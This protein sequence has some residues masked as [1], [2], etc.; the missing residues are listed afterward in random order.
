MKEIPRAIEKNLSWLATMK[1]PRG[2][3]GPVVHYWNNS[4]DYIGPGTDW[5]YEG[6]IASFLALHEKT[7]E[8]RFLDLAIESGEFILA[9]R[10]S[11]GGFF[12]A[13]FEANPSF[14]GIGTPHQS[15]V[16]L[17][18][19]QLADRLK[20]LGLNYQ[21]FSLAAKENL[22]KIHMQKLWSEQKQTFFQFDKK[23]AANDQNAFVP[24]KISTA[25]QAFFAMYRHTG[26]KRF[27][28]IGLKA[29]EYV[30]LM[31]CLDNTEWFGGIFQ[32]NDRKKIFSFYTARCIPALVQGYE[33]SQNKAFSRAIEN[34]LVFLNSMQ[35]ADGSHAAGFMQIDSSFQKT[36]LPNFAAGAGDIGLA[37]EIGK[38]FGKANSRSVMDWVLQNAGQSGGF[39]SARG[40]M[41]KNQ[42]NAPKK[43]EYS[44]QDAV[45]VVGW[46]DKA[47]CFL[48]SACKDGVEL[49]PLGFEESQKQ[50]SNGVLLETQDYIGVEHA[51]K[52][53]HFEKQKNFSNGSVVLKNIFCRIGLLDTPLTD[54]IAR[55]GLR[56]LRDSNERN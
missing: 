15:A 16:A 3:A 19:I 51:K 39:F 21:K 50:C 24:N 33:L 37:L 56:V 29:L 46:N 44:W 32:S 25:C 40:L 5:R 34:A 35:N 7:G 41:H 30:P 14:E 23:R 6:L 38:P 22:E 10:R 54:W 36:P 26:E 43:A 49:E 20:S 55:G 17:A 48:S 31:Q 52:N 28:D 9:N 45:P 42:P 27:L 13:S 8:K 18:L 47:L 12:F 53:W 2:Y 4:L 1:T 11:N